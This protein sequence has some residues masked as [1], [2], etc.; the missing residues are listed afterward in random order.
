MAL[1]PFV[2]RACSQYGSSDQCVL[3][4]DL[5]IMDSGCV[6][7]VVCRAMSK[8]SSGKVE[9]ASTAASW[10][11]L[12]CSCEQWGMALGRN[13]V[14][15]CCSCGVCDTGVAVYYIA[16]LVLPAW[17]CGSHVHGPS[18]CER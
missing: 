5:Q 15:V 12:G 16:A 18:A 10:L 17:L 7:R 9:V 1:R 2:E 13:S 8:C 3:M 4:S 14:G 6:Y 11:C